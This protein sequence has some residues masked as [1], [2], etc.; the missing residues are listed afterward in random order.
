VTTQ[1]ADPSAA[2]PDLPAASPADEFDTRR[3]IA[4]RLGASQVV[5]VFATLPVWVFLG[6]TKMDG[7][8]SALQ[9]NALNAAVVG[10]PLAVLAGAL[11]GWQAWRHERY[12]VAMRWN[13][14]PLLWLVPLGVIWYASWV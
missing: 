3:R 12:R 14:L 7:S 5:F 8:L 10:Y 2:A 11:L 6:L 13:S 1:P 9:Q 4:I